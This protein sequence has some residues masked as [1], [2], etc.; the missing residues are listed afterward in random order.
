MTATPQTPGF[1]LTG[2]DMTHGE[3]ARVLYRLESGQTELAR[4][5]RRM[6]VIMALAVG[7]GTT[8]GSGLGA[9]VGGVIGG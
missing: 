2:S 9:A 3:I 4:R 6:E 1:L 5:V 8:L 7:L